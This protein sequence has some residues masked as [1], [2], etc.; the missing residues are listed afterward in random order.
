M[1]SIPPWETDHQVP[2]TKRHEQTRRDSKE[3]PVALAVGD[4]PG[5]CCTAGERQRAA[6]GHPGPDSCQ[7]SVNIPGCQHGCLSLPPPFLK[8][9]GRT[10]AGML[11]DG[12]WGWQAGPQAGTAFCQRTRGS[13]H[14]ALWIAQKSRAGDVWEGDC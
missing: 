14:G 6:G 3:T 9:C 10:D 4:D 11:A 5:K 12:V 1:T 2:A 8:T 7:T 13:G